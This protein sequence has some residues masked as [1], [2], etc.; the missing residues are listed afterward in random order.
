MQQEEGTDG[1]VDA[2]KASVGMEGGSKIGYYCVINW[3]FLL[4]CR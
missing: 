1:L 2:G 3:L 4:L